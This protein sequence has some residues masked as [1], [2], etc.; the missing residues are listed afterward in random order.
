MF[1]YVFVSVFMLACVW[2]GGMLIVSCPDH[3]S[4]KE[5]GLV[6]QVKFLELEAYYGMCNQCVIQWC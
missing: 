6:N 1:V 4:H 2:C 3:T 5:N